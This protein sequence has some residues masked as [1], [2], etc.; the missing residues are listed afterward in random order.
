MLGYYLRVENYQ[1]I[2]DQFKIVIF[3]IF[4]FV[5]VRRALNFY[6]AKEETVG[7]KAKDVEKGMILTKEWKQHFSEKISK[8]NK[9]DKHIHFEEVDPEGLTKRQAGIIRELF[10]DDPKYTVQVLNSFPFAPFMLFASLIS[11]ATSSSFIPLL[12]DLIRSI[13]F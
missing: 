3:F 1:I 6:I 13:I 2:I 12:G 4:L 5:L 8:L 9:N 10:E 7:V 11:I